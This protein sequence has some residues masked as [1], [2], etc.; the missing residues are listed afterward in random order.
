LFVAA[1]L[2]TRKRAIDE[3]SSP[4]RWRAP[5]W[6]V[7]LMDPTIIAFALATYIGSIATRY[8]ITVFHH[9]F[10]SI[11]NAGTPAF[12]LIIAIIVRLMLR[13][14]PAFGGATKNLRDAIRRS[15]FTAEEWSAL[16]W[17]FIGVLGSLGLHGVLHNFLYRH[18]EAFRSLR[19]PARWAIITYA[20]LAVWSALG[21]DLLLRARRGLQW[22]AAASA[23]AIVALLDVTPRFRWEQ[24][25]IDTPDVYRWLAKSGTKGPVIELPMSGWCVQ[26]MYL[27]RSTAH[28]VPIMNGTSGFEP[29]VHDR[30][31]NMAERGEMNDVFLA[32]LERNHAQYVIVHGDWLLEQRKA[33]MRFLNEQVANG[34][35]A[36]VRR[37]DHWT[38][39]DWVFALT[40]ANHE[41]QQ[42]RAALAP[43]QDVERFL[44]GEATYN[45]ST[46]FHVDTPK[47][48]D[49]P[50]GPLRV[51]GWMLSP[52]GI[53]RGR[54]FVDQG[55][56]Y[57]DAHISDRP[58]V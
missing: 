55:R 16:I 37:F 15:R 11:D 41:W 52:N 33:T 32:E 14:P 57:Y 2:L 51:A 43:N 54:V 1:L 34:R 28:H 6:L 38:E 5:N 8:E 48:G 22:S 45:G 12:F 30:L 39:G 20:G 23:I 4:P 40:H 10:I 44:R 42:Q 17:I 53:A 35:L 25:V 13:M 50:H 46:F 24:V 3:S 9:R 49:E 7:R 47:A 36:F 18:V 56:R 31:R 19:V 21:V 26:F 27:L 29:P 58:D